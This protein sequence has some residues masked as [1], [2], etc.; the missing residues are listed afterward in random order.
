MTTPLAP[1]L[2]ETL[3]TNTTAAEAVD[4]LTAAIDANEKLNLIATVDHSKGA[5]KAG[6]ELTPTIEI[7]VGNPAVGT[8]LMYLNPTIA[9]DLPQKLL[10]IETE[11]G[12]RVLHNDPVY[13]A[14]RHG[15]DP[16]TP[17]LAVQ[18][19]AIGGL[20]IAAAGA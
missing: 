12:V 8:P 5:E 15:I 1:G 16:A 20:A 7:F 17:Q 14:Q 13:L 6:L 4:R 18:A 3:G 10:I 19:G 9:I 2:I 11:T